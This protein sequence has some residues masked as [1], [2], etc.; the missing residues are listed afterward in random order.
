MDIEAISNKVTEHLLTVGQ[1]GLKFLF[2]AIVAL[3]ILVIGLY[4]SRLVSSWVKKILTKI[5]FDEKTSKIGI[6][7]LCVR[8]GLG[9]SPTYIIAFVL[10]WAV[11]FYAIV[12]AADFLNLTVIRDLFTRFLE[13]IPT[14]F[15]SVLILFAGLLFG[16]LMGNIIDNASRANNLK[17]GFLISRAVNIFIVFFCALIAV[18]N[19]GFATQLVN[20]VVVIVLASL[21]LAFGIG[22]GLGSKPLV[23]EFLRDLFKRENK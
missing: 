23:E 18:E 15:V 1:S 20:N 3:F 19:L 10:A 12:L 8:F 21:G 22:V 11:I 7:E 17:G 13:F 6:N 14:L 2:E 9:K 4:L 16:K 5:A